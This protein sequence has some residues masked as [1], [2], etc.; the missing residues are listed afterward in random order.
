MDWVEVVGFVTGAACVWL[1]ARQNVWTFPVGIANNA[2]FAVLFWQAGIGGN[3]GL[4]AVYLVLGVLAWSWWV[5]GGRGGTS[6][7][8]RRTPRAVWPVATATA[9]A[10]TV[11]LAAALGGTGTSVQPWWDGST[12]ALSLVAQV[13]LGRKWVGSW[14]VWILTDVLLVGLYLSLGLYLTAAL[15]VLFI[16]LCVHG[17]RSWSRDLA[18][19]AAPRP[20]PEGAVADGV[21]TPAPERV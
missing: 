18:A 3:A 17:W 2:F 20:V 1:A 12:T 19:P 13:M 16:G 8:V 10:L 7:A 11:A 6:L 4:Q 9:V 14:A 21:A 15:Y 5:R